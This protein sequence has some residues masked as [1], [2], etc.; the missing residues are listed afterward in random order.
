MVR[1]TKHIVMSA[2]I[3]AIYAVMT[4]SLYVISYG[5]IQFRLSE[6][7]TIL[8]VFTA[9]AIPG[10]TIG[11]II[12]NIMGGYGIMDVVFGGVATLLAAVCTRVFRKN[13]FM[14]L[15]SPVFFNSLIVGP[16][17][18]FVVP[19]SKSLLFNIFTVGAGEFV[20]C[21]AVGY[22]LIRLLKKYP[23]LFD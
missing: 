12:A 17:L 9:N 7:L 20:V 14:A 19:E 1:K 10:L 2:V 11:C 3:A 23:K 21:F 22:P 8:P 4:L 5:P 15:F 18:Y 6:A 16:M 13:S